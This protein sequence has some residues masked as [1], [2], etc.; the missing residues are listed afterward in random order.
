MTSAEQIQIAAD[1]IALDCAVSPHV[2]L[3]IA[4]RLHEIWMRPGG[5]QRHIPA[6]EIAQKCRDLYDLALES[7]APVPRN[8]APR[9][10][11]DDWD[12][13]NSKT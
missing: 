5:P 10:K 8:M 13:K 2:A 7:P 3:V 6:G 1:M 11:T 12:F 9:D 4:R